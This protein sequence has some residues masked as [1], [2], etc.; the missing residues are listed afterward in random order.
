VLLRISSSVR[1]N[2]GEDKHCTLWN[3][4]PNSLH[5]RVQ[6]ERKKNEGGKYLEI[7]LE[8]LSDSIFA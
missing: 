7:F 8:S 6:G 3:A 2:E 1:F 4:H 5:C